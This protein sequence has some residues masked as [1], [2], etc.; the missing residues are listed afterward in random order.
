MHK[1]KKLQGGGIPPFNQITTLSGNPAPLAYTVPASLDFANQ[2]KNYGQGIVDNINRKRSY[3]NNPIP[4]M[5]T[6]EQ[7]KAQV[8]SFGKT[9]TTASANKIGNLSG[10]LKKSGAGLLS[11]TNIATGVIKSLTPQAEDK[12]SQI[13]GQAMDTIGD[14]ASA[15]GPV[16]GLVGAGAKVL[17]TLITSIGPNVKGNTAK[18]LTDSSSSYGGLDKLDSKKF[19]LFGI[20]AGKRYAKKVAEREQQRTKSEGILKS[21]KTDQEAAAGS[22]QNLANRYNLN[23]SGGWQQNNGIRFGKSG[24]KMSY[25]LSFAHKVLNHLKEES[26]K[27]LQQGGKPRSIEELINFAKKS[28]P[29]FIQR[30]SEAPRGIEFVDDDGNTAKGSH[31]LE[32]A[33]EYVIP[34]IQ[35]V[36]GELK[37]FNHKDAI[38]RAIET[39]NYLKMTPEEAIIFAKEYKKGWPKFFEKFEK[40][41]K[42]NIIPE[43][44]LHARKHNIDTPELDGKI[45]KKGIPVIV[46]GENGIKQV[47]EIEKNEI[48]FTK[49]ITEK[50]EELRDKYSDDESSSKEKDAIAIEAGK[51]LVQEILYN[52]QDN[53]GLLN[54]VE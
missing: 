50:L 51:L 6:P 37:F 45:T 42:V 33:G 29:R 24:A 41:G 12:G 46:E 5:A 15:F 9:S 54:E 3:L 40:G 4:G 14:I 17:G 1:I 39:G 38:N 19:G 53:T 30:L 43:G 7:I 44:A 21:A 20:G 8:D 26:P 48:I 25:D 52:T 18:E 16:G 22:I 27:K 49:E 47:A 32:S 2:F 10:F 11:G 35:E 34:R 28:N 31:Y 23:M 36:D 13:T